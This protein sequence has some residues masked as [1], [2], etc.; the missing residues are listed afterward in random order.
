MERIVKRDGLSV[1]CDSAGTYSGH[2]GQ[3]ADPRMKFWAA[4]RGYELTHLARP[5]SRADFERFDMII[6]M[7][8]SVYESL[9]RMAP[10]VEGG[11]R[12]FRMN[13]FFGERF[14]RDWTY[15]PD[16]YYEGQEGFIL[17]LDMLEEACEILASRLFSESVRKDK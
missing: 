16:P 9:W 5:V 10:S 7:D 15:V 8:D 3:G 11:D 12:I 13:E 17:V 6:A 4:K 2:A 14:S 1:E